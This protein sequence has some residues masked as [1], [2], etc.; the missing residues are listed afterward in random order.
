MRRKSKANK[1][2][3]VSKKKEIE[4]ILFKLSTHIR[5]DNFLDISRESEKDFTR[6]RK[7][8]F[9]E[10]IKFILNFRTKSTQAE[11]NIFYNNIN[12]PKKCAFFKAR[13]KLKAATF[14]DILETMVSY[15]YKAEGLVKK[16]KGFRL[17]AGDMSSFIIPSTGSEIIDKELISY[18]GLAKSKKKQKLSRGT[19][20]FYMIR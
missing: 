6:T 16:W 17:I 18:F 9:T 20:I 13:T 19:D 12:T 11:L 5:S 8:P 1:K 4:N 10:L 14:L 2:N 3:R 7:L 15:F